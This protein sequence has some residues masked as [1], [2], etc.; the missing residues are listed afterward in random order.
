WSRTEM[1]VLP[2]YL[3]TSRQVAGRPYACKPCLKASKAAARVPNEP[4]TGQQAMRG[5]GE[6]RGADVA[7]ADFGRSAARSKP[8]R[9]SRRYCHEAEA[10]PALPERSRFP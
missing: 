10:K 4:S 3:S 5:A 2:C 8:K 9:V 7:G 1:P 6:G